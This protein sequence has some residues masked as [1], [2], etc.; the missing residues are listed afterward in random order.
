MEMNRLAFDFVIVGCGLAGTAAALELCQW[1]DVAV[2]SKE[3]V[4]GCN[5]YWAQGGI[6]AAVDHGDSEELHVADTLNAGH[7]LCHPAVVA[8]VAGAAPD[9]VRW[10]ERLGVSFMWMARQGA[11]RWD[12]KGHTLGGASG[13][14]EEMRAGKT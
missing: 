10:L 12:W 9:R 3:P 2:V 6:A 13:T 7:G 1:G 14:P 5:S 11:S 8:D 4:T